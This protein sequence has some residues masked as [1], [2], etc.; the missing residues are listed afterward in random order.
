MK[1]SDRN[2]VPVARRCELGAAE[3]HQQTSPFHPAA[4]LDAP[5]LQCLRAAGTVASEVPVLRLAHPHCR[6]M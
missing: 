6:R 1:L 3:H 2:A 4:P 5:T